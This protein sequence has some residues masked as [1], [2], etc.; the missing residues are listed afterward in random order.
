M[1][2]HLP[3]AELIRKTREETFVERM[4][5]GKLVNMTTSIFALGGA[6]LDNEFNHVAQKFCRGLGIVAIENQARI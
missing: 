6:T 2:A 5:D 3:L 4:P 1:I